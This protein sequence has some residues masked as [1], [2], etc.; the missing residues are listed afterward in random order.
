MDAVEDHGFICLN[1]DTLSRMRDINQRSSNIDLI[2][3]SQEVSAMV[4][5]Q[6]IKDL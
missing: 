3:C 6:Q 5:Y 4:E 1:T 2:L